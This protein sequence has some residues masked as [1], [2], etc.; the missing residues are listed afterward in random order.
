MTYSAK[1]LQ[2]CESEEAY[3][4]RQYEFMQDKQQ[5][6]LDLKQALAGVDDNM[7]AMRLLTAM[8]P[9][10]EILAPLLSRV[11]DLAIDSGSPDRIV[12]AREVLADYKEDLGVRNHIKTLVKSYLDTDEWHYWRIAELYTRLGYKEELASFLVLCR[13]SDNVEIQE[14]SDVFDGS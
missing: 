11:L 2:L 1:W 4:I 3:R 14:I 5:M 10:V 13:A 7:T 9:G 8:K 12:L 6:A